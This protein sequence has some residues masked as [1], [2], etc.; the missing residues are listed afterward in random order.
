M[1]RNCIF[2]NLLKTSYYFHLWHCKKEYLCYCF[3]IS[4]MR[5]KVPPISI[6]W[7]NNT[8]YL[9]WWLIINNFL[10]YSR[11]AFNVIFPTSADVKDPVVLPSCIRYNQINKWFNIIAFLL[12][13]IFCFYLEIT[14]LSIRIYIT[15]ECKVNASIHN[16]FTAIQ[17]YRIYPWIFF[18]WRNMSSRCIIKCWK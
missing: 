6:E 3:A 7:K 10:H 16:E 4:N 18:Y 14:I 9:N 13:N 11:I 15:T 5:C 17:R 12:W 8:G 2:Q 1:Q